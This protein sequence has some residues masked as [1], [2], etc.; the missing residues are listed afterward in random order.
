MKL[1]VK[2][3][4]IEFF[5]FPFFYFFPCVS[6][7]IQIYIVTHRIKMQT[8]TGASVY[9]TQKYILRTQNFFAIHIPMSDSI[10]HWTI[11]GLY[12]PIRN[13]QP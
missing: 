1:F 2:M 9:S 4:K 3:K 13:Q 12:I 5:D 10:C 6:Q 8:K 7:I 11:Y